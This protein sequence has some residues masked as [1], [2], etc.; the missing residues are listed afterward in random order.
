MLLCYALLLIS[1]SDIVF[2][3]SIH[4]REH[5]TIKQQFS[6]GGYFVLREHFTT[7]GGRFLLAP[8]R[9][10]P[11]HPTMHGTASTTLIICFKMPVF[12]LRNSAIYIEQRVANSTGHQ[13]SE[14]LVK[15]II[16]PYQIP[17]LVGFGGG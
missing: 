14:R 15:A 3:N 10:A 13:S 1:Y 4:I 17:D 6:T 5:F 2:N 8:S 16:A 12:S 9:D 7:T 11:Q